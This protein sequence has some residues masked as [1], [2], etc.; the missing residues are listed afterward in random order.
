MKRQKPFQLAQVDTKDIYDKGSLETEIEV[1][2]YLMWGN[3]HKLLKYKKIEK[4]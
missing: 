3:L 2:S 4:N 1:H